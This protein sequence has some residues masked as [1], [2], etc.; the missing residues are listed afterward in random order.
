MMYYSTGLFVARG[1]VTLI[2][3]RSSAHQQPNNFFSHT[4]KRGQVVERDL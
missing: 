4:R 1:R 2:D 3:H